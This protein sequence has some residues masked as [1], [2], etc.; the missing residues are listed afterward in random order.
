[1]P[2]GRLVGKTIISNDLVTIRQHPDVELEI[3]D[4]LA[5]DTSSG[6]T[7]LQVCSVDTASQFSDQA[8]EKAAGMMMDD[9]TIE[10]LE[11]AASNYTTAKAKPLAVMSGRRFM[12]PKTAIPIF[13]DMSYATEHD[14]QF[15]NSGG[16]HLDLGIIRSG[17]KAL[18][19]HFT[20][21]AAKVISHHI[22]VVA[23]TGRGKSNFIKCMLYGMLGT[24]NVGM[25]VLDAHGEY[26]A[27]LSQHPMAKEHATF[28]GGDLSLLV[29]I[30]S[31]RPSHLRGV[32]ELTEAQERSMDSLYHRHG[33]DWIYRLMESL[34]DIESIENGKHVTRA[35]LAGKVR[36]ALGMYRSGGAFT[37]DHDIGTDTIQNIIERLNAGQVVVVDMSTL[38]EQ[39]EQTM[40]NLLAES[41]LYSRRRAA[42]EGHIDRLPP[43]GVIV[44]EAPRML[45]VTQ[46]GNAYSQIAR[47]GRK[48][49]VGIVAVTQLASII[50]RDILVNLS[51]KVIF[52]NEMNVER[53]AII[54]SA[55]QDL[56]ADSHNIASLN[57][58]EAIISSVFAPFAVPIRVPLFDDLVPKKPRLKVLG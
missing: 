37:I 43:L 39:E 13:T 27:A 3:G 16:R 8:R 44:E 45:S 20:M 23:S 35:A 38:G 18:D 30:E 17:S 14:M 32:V 19:V 24:C 42:T 48:F 47:E 56:S 49:K 55:A 29:N 12:K 41:I 11:R 7:L 31:I 25:L 33:K 5:C 28:Y 36:R 1:M 26:R 50:P 15:L 9:N 6:I 53:K 21:D 34:D 10:W 4:L 2:L 51:T 54:E 58:G 40:G 57:P 52:G 46:G 22:L